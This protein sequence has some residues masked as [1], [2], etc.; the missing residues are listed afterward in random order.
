MANEREGR[1]GEE[2]ADL[3]FCFFPHLKDFLVVDTRA[4]LPNGPAVHEFNAADVYNDRFYRDLEAGFSDLL[5]DRDEPFAALMALSVH[6]EEMMRERGM[7]AMLEVVGRTF[8]ISKPPQ[9]SIVVF[10]GPLL[11][12][13]DG[14]VRDALERLFPKGALGALF[15]PTSQKLLSLLARERERTRDRRR[16]QAQRGLLQGNEGFLTLWQRPPEQGAN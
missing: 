7:D 4:D 11:N 6:V 10:A 9:I 13:D 15:M 2:Q 14:Q 12:A 1:R 3:T 5:R 16:E 8:P